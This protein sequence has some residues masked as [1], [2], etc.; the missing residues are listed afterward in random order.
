MNNIDKINNFLQV[1]KKFMME[2]PGRIDTN[3]I[4]SRL[5]HGISNFNRPEDISFYFKDF[6]DLNFKNMY[7][8]RNERASSFCLFK[9]KEYFGII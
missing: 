4:Y 3:F 1:I 6:L 5:C 2:N 9:S 8:Y 7:S